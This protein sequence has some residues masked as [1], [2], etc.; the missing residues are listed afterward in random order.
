MHISG[1]EQ[2]EK[3]MNKFRKLAASIAA[4]T[5]A[6]SL[7]VGTLA[8]TANEAKKAIDAKPAYTLAEKQFIDSYSKKGVEKAAK[9]LVDNGIELTEAKRMVDMYIEGKQLRAEQENMKLSTKG[10]NRT[11]EL[12][13]YYSST[14]LSGQPHYGVI[15]SNG[16]IASTYYP[17]FNLTYNTN[18]HNISFPLDVRNRSTGVTKY[19]VGSSNPIGMSYCITTSSSPEAKF[20]FPF[21]VG[22]CASSESDL[23]SNFAFDNNSKPF[24]YETYVRGDTNH[25][26]WVDS[27]D[28]SFI[29]EY[30]ILN[31]TEADLR[32]DYSNNSYAPTAY[33]ARLVNELACDLD[34]NGAIELNDLIMIS[35]PA[36]RDD[37]PN[38]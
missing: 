10:K 18:Y 32:S 34:G 25:D 21:G 35:Q 29:F 26:G 30:N 7:S 22:V 15:I 14:R 31:V 17:Y 19:Y 8:V 36:N 28:Y 2:E 4:I 12:P 20:E 6:L 3:L 37:L 16:N 38:I 23:Y 24:Q 1:H 27:L 33:I 11:E 9:Y 5:T 13:E